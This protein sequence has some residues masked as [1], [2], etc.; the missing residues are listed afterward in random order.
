MIGSSTVRRGV[1]AACAALAVT[2]GVA[3]CSSGD[4]S[5]GKTVLN[6]YAAASLNKV[7]TQ[8]A[9][10]YEKAHDDVDVKLNFAGSS[11]LVNQI[12]QGADADVI[13]TADEATMAKLGD[14][15]ENPKVF[16]TNT[17]VIA[18]AP[19][20]PKRIANFAGLADPAIKTT[21][22]AVEVPCGAA[23]AAVE[24]NTGVDIKPVSEETSVSAVLA[25]VT[26]GQADAGLVYVTDAKGAGDKVATVT[27]PAFAA[28]VNKYPIA[29]LKD[30]EHKEDAEMF[31]SM[32]LGQNGAEVLGDAGFAPP[33]S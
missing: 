7:F 8:L 21:V 15:V 19:G 3:A 27:D 10:Y 25:K 22:C 33:T 29:P 6:V 17:L 4:D 31:V 16:A 28:V 9:E 14:A 24:K 1:A 23:T 2:A 20:N 26:S 18:T 30:S 32:V 5:G 11:A 13:A 12:D